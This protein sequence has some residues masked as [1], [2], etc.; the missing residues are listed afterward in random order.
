MR[1]PL[2]GGPSTVLTSLALAGVLIGLLSACAGVPTE[3]PIVQGPAVA[4]GGQDQ[5]IRVIARPPEIGM[6]PEEIVRGFQEATASPDAGYTIARQFLAPT[7][8]AAWDPSIG[9]LVGDN[10]GLTYSRHDQVVVAEGGLSGSI[11]GSG[12]YTAAVPG[13]RLV[14]SYGVVK[15]AGEWRI[16]SLPPGL[17]LGPGDID[18]GFRTFNLYYFTRDFEVLVPAP[19]VVPLSGSGLATQLVR[20]LLAGPTEWLAPAVR[21][22][23]P[24]GT[25]LALDSVPIVEGVADVALTPEILTADDATRQALSAQLVW[26][27]RQLPEI[28]AVRLRVNGQPVPVAGAIAP[29]PVEAWARFDP[30]ALSDSALAYADSRKGLI[31]IGLEGALSAVGRSKP[32]LL[33]HAIS[34]DSTRLAGLSGDRKSVWT[35]DLIPGAI[36][37]RRYTGLSLSRPSWDRSGGLWVVDRGRGLVLITDTTKVLVPVTG[38][39]EGVADKDIVAVAVAR[40]G[41]RMALL[42]RRGTLV[43]PMIAR[44]ERSADDVKVAAPRRIDSIVTEAV[45]L[46]WLDAGTLVVLGTSGASALEVLQFDTGTSR[47]RRSGSI[48]GSVT[49]AAAPGR[50][51]LIGTV[52]NLY[53]SSGSSW[54]ILAAGSNPVYPG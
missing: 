2:V 6:S 46:A 23:F 26:T 30:N 8:A 34:L 29:Q 21:T 32:G 54:S 20:D 27:L 12:Q 25:A 31:A 52:K 4:A 42:L 45:D 3:G 13:A 17:V 5:F 38:L 14:S 35:A 9:V 15:F 11:D 44:V 16:S 37:T 47:V 41:T 1:R 50:A 19:V 28:S 51:V 36:A 53:R 18:R 33:Q 24:E 43:E 48:E 10:A 39:P 40:D 22:A 7:V 49:I